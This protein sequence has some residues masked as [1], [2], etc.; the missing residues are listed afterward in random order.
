MA[1]ELE[2]IPKLPVL[3]VQTVIF[4][5]NIAIIK[6]L[7]VEPYLKVKAE[8]ETTTQGSR[9]EAIKLQAHAKEI[10][11]ELERRLAEGLKAIRD[12]RESI[13]RLA[14]NQRQALIDE[15]SLEASTWSERA[16]NEL[17]QVIAREKEK[18]P[19]VVSLLKEEVFKL[20]ISA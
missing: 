9:D 11:E 19:T 5:A 8:R 15:A 18:I 7:F 4:I 20:T 3:A 12:Q 16:E 6:K 1:A 13:R 17:N 2:L 14:L 10:E